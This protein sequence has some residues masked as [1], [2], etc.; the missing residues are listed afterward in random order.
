MCFKS[1][2]ETTRRSLLEWAVLLPAGGAFLAEWA[3]AG[4]AHVHG[5]EAPP[6]VKRFREYQPQ[7][8]SA[9]D[10]AALQSLTEILI[11]SDGTPGAREAYC[12]CFI[13]FMLQAMTGHTPET[14][15]QWRKAMRALEEAG[16]QSAERER[17]LAIVAEISRPEREPGVKHPAFAAYR[18][19]KRENAFA[20][21]TARE[22]MIDCLDYRGNTYNVTFPGCGHA[23]HRVL[24][25]EERG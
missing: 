3:K 23:E 6:E 2:T 4:Q 17:R 11:P 19:I 8:F 24:P 22:G 1:E 16:F 13:D 12:G 7:F 5:S 21:Y 10:F 9:N 14:Q 15:E 25:A 18:L 20:F